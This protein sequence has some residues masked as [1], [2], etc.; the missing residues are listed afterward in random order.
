MQQSQ[1]N[2]ITVQNLSKLIYK[3]K[4]WFKKE[5]E[6]I[7]H[8]IS[9]SVLSNEFVLILMLIVSYIVWKQDLKRY[10]APL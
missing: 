4:G 10:A 2:I 9:F 1:S 5:T 8:P 3:A 7:L 6:V